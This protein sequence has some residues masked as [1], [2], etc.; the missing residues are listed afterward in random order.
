MAGSLRANGLRFLADDACAIDDDGR[1]WPGPPLTAGEHFVSD[2]ASRELTRYDGSGSS[3]SSRE[4]ATR[5][6]SGRRRYS[7]RAMSGPCHP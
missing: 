1:I 6:R 7:I 2:D 5:F 3:R 4:L